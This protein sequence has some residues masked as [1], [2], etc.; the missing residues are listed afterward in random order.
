M[1]GGARTDDFKGGITSEHSWGEM[2]GGTEA[3]P[4]DRGGGDNSQK[5]RQ[6]VV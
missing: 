5:R 3:N 4:D 6:E 1:G 2:E